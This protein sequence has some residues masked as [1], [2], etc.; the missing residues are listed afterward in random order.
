MAEQ[1]H[2]RDDKLLKL[3]LAAFATACEQSEPEL[4]L[5]N[6][7]AALEC[8]AV[9]G[10]A[11][12]ATV[13]AVNSIREK[14]AVNPD[15]SDADQILLDR[16]FKPLTSGG[17]REALEV[18]AAQVDAPEELRSMIARAYR[19]R[20]AYIHSAVKQDELESLVNAM[21]KLFTLILSA[22]TN[23]KT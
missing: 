22:R 6:I 23:S 17:R 11:P 18:L 16:A 13:A 1:E 10:P 9:H 5:L 2:V 3:A 20:G 21:M 14:V 19:A 15:F 4:R 7:F 12:E 8:L